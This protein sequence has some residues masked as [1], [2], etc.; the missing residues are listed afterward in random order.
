MRQRETAVAS[1][2][3]GASVLGCASAV[4]AL[5]IVRRARKTEL[6]D[7]YILKIGCF[8]LSEDHYNASIVY[9]QKLWLLPP[10]H[11]W[12]I[13]RIFSKNNDP[14][15]INYF[16]TTFTIR[17]T[18]TFHPICNQTCKIMLV[19]VQKIW[20]HFNEEGWLMILGQTFMNS[21]MHTW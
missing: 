8:F 21:I 6:C 4:A 18:S 14:L 10:V 7:G 3:C 2:S 12:T 1:G 20:Q 15:G 13:S 11:V 17:K 16:A 9:L 5:R 19:K